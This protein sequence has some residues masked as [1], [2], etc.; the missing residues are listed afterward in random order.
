MRITL[1][2]HDVK[3]IEQIAIERAYCKAARAAKTH[4]IVF[5]QQHKVSSIAWHDGLCTVEFEAITQKVRV[6]EKITKQLTRHDY[7]GTGLAVCEQ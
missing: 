6:T 1:D 2:K 3:I 5:K 7:T 4:P